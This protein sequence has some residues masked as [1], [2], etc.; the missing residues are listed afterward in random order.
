MIFKIKKLTSWI[1]Q[2]PPSNSHHFPD[3]YMFRILASCMGYIDPTYI[4]VSP[5]FPHGFGFKKSGES[6]I[7]LPKSLEKWDFRL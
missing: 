6:V 7:W 4:I 5:C 3:F 1:Y 2:V